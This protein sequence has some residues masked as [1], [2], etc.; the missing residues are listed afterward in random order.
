MSFFE[1]LK[2]SSPEQNKNEIEKITKK[3]TKKKTEEWPRGTKTKEAKIS[4]DLY[5]TAENLVIQSTI[6]GIKA[7]DLNISVENGILTITGN[8][9]KQDKDSSTTKKYLYQEC[10]WGP[11]A[12]KIILPESVDFSRINAAVK[13]GI[14]TIEIPKI[15]KTTKRRIEIIEEE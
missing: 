3:E 15:Q 11:F 5:E 13:E 2:S 9:E 8:R 4:I 12:R 14:L 6:A 7:K 10:Y 1:K